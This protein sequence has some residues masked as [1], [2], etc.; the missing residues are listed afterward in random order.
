MPH[1]DD[2]PKELNFDREE[3][4][5]TVEDFLTGNEILKKDAYEFMPNEW[6]SNEYVIK[7]TEEML[8]NDLNLQPGETEF[9]NLIQKRVQLLFNL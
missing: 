2:E 1:Y 5:E 4:I 9:F 6:V 7:A 8:H 3:T